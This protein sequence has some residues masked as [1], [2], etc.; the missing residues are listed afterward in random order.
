[1][2]KFV[3][4]CFIFLFLTACGVETSSSNLDIKR[5]SSN[6][7]TGNTDS[8]NTDSDNTDSDNTDS[9]NTD[10]DNTDTGDTDKVTD[11]IFDTG[12]AIEDKFACM[13][14]DPNDGYTRNSISDTS[15]DPVGAF[16]EEYGVG[17]NSRF[18]NHVDITRTNVTVFYYDLKP[19]RSM[20]VVGIYEDDFR[21]S[22]DT[23]WANNDET[24]LYAMTPKDANNLYGCY[25]YDLS[26]IDINSTVTGTKV[27]RNKI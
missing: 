4:A 22:I 9:D 24:T 12:G 19:T 17:V 20:D 26:S 13:L 14:G 11:S 18:P 1:M 16:D 25:R 27:Y 21:I 15:P 6:S 2:L 5:S 8:D 3:F 7:D 23:G 10:S